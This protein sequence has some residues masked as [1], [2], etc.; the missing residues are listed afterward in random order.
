MA[1]NNTT[2]STEA[3]RTRWRKTMITLAG[4]WHTE[5]I[6]LNVVEAPTSMTGC[7]FTAANAY[8]SHLEKELS[9]YRESMRGAEELAAKNR[10]A[11]NDDLAAKWAGVAM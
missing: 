10:E 11:L 6:D 9:T 7:F 1:D 3:L 5:P 4:S 2:T 8:I